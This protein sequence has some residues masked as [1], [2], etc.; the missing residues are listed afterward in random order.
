MKFFEAYQLAAD[1]HRFRTDQAG[2]PYILHLVRVAARV[3]DAGG[4]DD[5]LA[6]ALLHDAIE[7][8]C[9]TPARLLELG[10]PAEAVRLVQ[11]LS[12]D[13]EEA[14]LDYVRRVAADPVASVIKAADLADNSDPERLA[15][16]DPYTA[17][18]LQRKYTAAAQILFHTTL[19]EEG[20]AA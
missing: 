10:V 7:D 8:G 20:A 11:V 1:L 6:A 18:R 9:A 4:S 13:P 12:K 3:A 2:E 5:Q 17:A 19:T 15:A 14:Y 16:L